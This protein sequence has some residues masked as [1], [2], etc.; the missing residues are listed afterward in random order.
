MKNFSNFMRHFQL[1]NCRIVV[2]ACKEL[3]CLIRGESLEPSITPE[4]IQEYMDD[5]KSGTLKSLPMGGYEYSCC[6]EYLKKIRQILF[7]SRKDFSEIVIVFH[8]LNRYHMATPPLEDCLF[9][10]AE[11]VGFEV[12]DEKILDDRFEYT[13]VSTF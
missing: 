4:T 8:E 1:I 5:L 3:K 10:V 7:E 11:E 12:T 2:Y 13:L 6:V 9:K